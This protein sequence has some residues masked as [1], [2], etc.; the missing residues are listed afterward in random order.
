MSI[1]TTKDLKTEYGI[2]I[3]YDNLVNIRYTTD[4]VFISE[5]SFE[6]DGII[7]LC[8]ENVS[9]GKQTI[10]LKEIQKVPVLDIKMSFLINMIEVEQNINTTNLNTFDYYYILV[11]DANDN[12]FSFIDA[13]F[14]ISLIDDKRIQDLNYRFVHFELDEPIKINPKKVL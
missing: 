6:E 1:I 5:I 13:P 11:R 8:H 3:P 12:K 4:G 9:K 10:S 14:K 2:I 7:K